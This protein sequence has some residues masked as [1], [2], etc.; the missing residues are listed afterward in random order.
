MGDSS[1]QPPTFQDRA[2]VGGVCSIVKTNK[3]EFVISGDSDLLQEVFE[4][5][6]EQWL[7]CMALKD[8]SK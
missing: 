7:R 5:R 4:S 1:Q 3:G 8:K 6:P 2:A